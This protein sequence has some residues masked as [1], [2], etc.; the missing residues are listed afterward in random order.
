MIHR[1][2]K[3]N[4]VHIDYL[5]LDAKQVAKPGKKVKKLISAI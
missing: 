1:E 2:N 5:L 4:S 3:N